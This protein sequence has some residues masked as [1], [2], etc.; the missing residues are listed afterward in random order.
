LRN[1]IAGALTGLSA[2]WAWITWRIADW[3]NPMLGKNWVPARMPITF[4]VDLDND[5]FAAVFSNYVK[6]SG[7]RAGDRRWFRW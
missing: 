4:C 2:C 7:N 1:A 3:F 6:V 5:G